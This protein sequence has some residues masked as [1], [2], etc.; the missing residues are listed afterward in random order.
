MLKPFVPIFC[1]CPVAIK[2]IVHRSKKQ[3]GSNYSNI[4]LSHKD[5][6]SWPLGNYR[7]VN[8]SLYIAAVTKEYK[9]MSTGV[10]PCVIPRHGHLRSQNIDSRTIDIPILPSLTQT[11][12]PKMLLICDTILVTK[13][14]ICGAAVATVTI[15]AALDRM[16][17]TRSSRCFFLA[18]FS[19]FIW[20]LIFL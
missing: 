6:G 4:L 12:Q 5:A 17:F 20:S 18:S 1:F 13:S 19:A 8:S 7:G 2:S 14:I 11:I 9:I 16:S 15:F 10:L 3:V